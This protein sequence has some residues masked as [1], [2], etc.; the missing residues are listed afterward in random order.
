MLTE[1]KK[2]IKTS[3]VDFN[4]DDHKEFVGQNSM[5]RLKEEINAFDLERE[6]VEHVTLD[7]GNDKTVRLLNGVCQSK[8]VCKNLGSNKDFCYAVETNTIGNHLK[9][10]LQNKTD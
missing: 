6:F 2:D 7:N 8:K 9:A 4:Y 10:L 3:I 5:C 1:L